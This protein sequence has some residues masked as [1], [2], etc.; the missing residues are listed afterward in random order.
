[1]MM[2]RKEF[3][4]MKAAAND[5]G[6]LDHVKSFVKKTVFVGGMLITILTYTFSDGS[7]LEVQASGQEVIES[8]ILVQ[9][10][11][12][13]LKI[14]KNTGTTVA[15]V[16]E[17]NQ[18]ADD[19][20]YAGQTL[21][22]PKNADIVEALTKTE[23][24]EVVKAKNQVASTTY[25]VQKGDNLTKIAT[26]TGV[27][28]AD[29][30]TYNS[31]VADLIFEGEELKLTGGVTPSVS[32]NETKPAS[33]SIISMPALTYIVQAGDTFYAL[34][35]KFGVDRSLIMEWNN[36][37]YANLIIGERIVIYGDAYQA[38]ATF[39]GAVDN[40][41]VAVTIDNEEYV[42][43]VGYSEATSYE[44]FNGKQKNVQW[45]QLPSGEQI[46]VNVK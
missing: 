33:N 43:Q 28:V 24:K 44:A 6:I 12:T 17:L 2:T 4:Q 40:H 23:I 7:T 27:S 25:V 15:S 19:R 10:G 31:F 35:Q 32:A 45:I 46:L 39:S 41:S 29:L 5:T 42:L 13:L 18:L 14:A 37:T 20:I 38:L 21:R 34:E 11:D 22:L 9:K 16:K 26:K 8:T 36:K 3:K 30:R 1:M